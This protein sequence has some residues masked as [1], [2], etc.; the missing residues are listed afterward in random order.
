MLSLSSLYHLVPTTYHYTFVPGYTSPVISPFAPFLTVLAA[1]QSDWCAPI[2]LQG[3]AVACG[4]IQ[5][6]KLDWIIAWYFNRVVE[7]L[8]TLVIIRPVFGLTLC[9]K[10]EPNDY[11]RW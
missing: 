2:D 9:G 10:G 8:P 6:R 11:E 4:Q 1:Q 7:S 3:S 5:R